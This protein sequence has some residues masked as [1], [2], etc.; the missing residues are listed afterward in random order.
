MGRLLLSRSAIEPLAIDLGIGHRLE[1]LNIDQM[2]SLYL[3]FTDTIPTM[4]DNIPH[5]QLIVT[6][7]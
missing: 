3:P 4:D 2:T 7:V 5:Y 1:V 6:M